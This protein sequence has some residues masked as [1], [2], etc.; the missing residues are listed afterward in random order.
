MTSLIALEIFLLLLE[1][2]LRI[3]VYFPAC[4]LVLLSSK[5]AEDLI[6]SFLIEFLFKNKLFIS[7]KIFDLFYFQSFTLIT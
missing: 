7:V 3:L 1:G 5:I 4:E 2:T 6:A